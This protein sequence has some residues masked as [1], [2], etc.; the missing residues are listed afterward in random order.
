MVSPSCSLQP[1]G[2]KSNAYK[3]TAKTTLQTKTE[4]FFITFSFFKIPQ[5]D[6]SSLTTAF[7]PVSRHIYYSSSIKSTTIYQFIITAAEPAVNSNRLKNA[8]SLVREYLI[9]TKLT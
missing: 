2:K 1:Q 8:S 4:V 9:K 6:Y 3:T 7:V 5:A